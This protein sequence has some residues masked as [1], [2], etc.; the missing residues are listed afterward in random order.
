MVLLCIKARILKRPVI[1]LALFAVALAG[2]WF[3]L[4]TRLQEPADPWDMVPGNAVFAYE[5]R[6][7]VSN[8]NDLL[9]RPIGHSL[10]G[11]TGFREFEAGLE[12][13]DSLTGKTG[14]LDLLFRGNTFLATAHITSSTSFGMLLLLDMSRADD[15]QALA[16]LEDGLLNYSGFSSGVRQYQGVEIYEISN[17]SNTRTFSYIKHRNVIAGSFTPFLVEDVIRQLGE[18][19][20]SGF[21][22]NTMGLRSLSKLETDQGNLYVDYVSLPQFRDIFVSPEYHGSITD[23][24]RLTMSGFF[25]IRITDHEIIL[26]GIG[27]AVK[28]DAP[29]ALAQFSG[30]NAATVEAVRYF[31]ERT[32]IA[33]VYNFSDFRSWQASLAGYWSASDRPQW[34]RYTAFESK[35]D[36]ALDWIGHELAF[37]ELEATDAGLPDRLLLIQSPEPETGVASL[38]RLQEMINTEPGDSLYYEMF[39]EWEIAQLTYPELPQALFGPSFAGFENIF[40]TAWGRYLLIGNS[41]RS[42]RYFLTEVAMDN[43]WGKSVRFT[44]FIDNTMGESSYSYFVNLHN[45]RQLLG[46]T[47]HNSWGQFWQDNEGVLRSF[48]LLAFQISHLENHYYTSLA[49]GYMDMPPSAPVTGRSGAGIALTLP[50]KVITRPFLVRNHVDNTQEVLLQDSLRSLMLIGSDGKVLWSKNIGAEIRTQIHQIDY[51]KNRKLQYLFATA[52][53]LWLIDRNGDNVSGF[54]LSL[55]AGTDAEHLSVVDYDNNRDY[56][57]M[58]ADRKGNIML[59]SKEG[60]ILDGWNPLAL[61]HPQAAAPFHLRVRGGDCM[62]ALQKRGQLHVMR[63]RGDSYP[64][65][66]VDLGMPIRGPLFIDQGNDFRTTLINTVTEGGEIV[67]VNLNGAV[68]RREQLVKPSADCIFWLVPDALGKT[69]AIV[70]REYNKLSFLDRRGQL[71][72]EQSFITSGALDVQYYQFSAERQYFAVTDREQE[73][74]YLFD[75]SGTLFN[76]QPLESSYPIALL[77]LSKENKY[78][79]YRNFQNSHIKLVFE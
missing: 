40:I 65:F 9:S 71:H 7:A 28:E 41:S 44:R 61:G 30:Q 57:F 46:A 56:R 8:W 77:Y 15:R 45:S 2:F 21:A 60:A 19:K 31:P 22:G 16:A 1:L 27:Q 68:V 47:L 51:F 23:L 26:N 33:R 24:N 74:T 29:D 49:L 79:L 17:R 25:D 32:T 35:Y 43:V 64:G 72:F 59:Y 73:F 4:R 39:N 75:K 50:S 36:L 55:G 5:S 66:P 54:P 53:Q 52:S 76:Q 11:I 14:T 58:L 12:M 42:I 63:R 69:Y 78:H 70:R 10:R 6:N 62:I 13:L 3:Y 67:Q 34:D 48:D 20:Y 38:R 18:K 37:V